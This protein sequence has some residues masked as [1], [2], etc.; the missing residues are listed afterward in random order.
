MK[1]ATLG[2]LAL[3]IGG[4]LLAA[5]SVLPELQHF[6]HESGRAGDHSPP[7]GRSHVAVFR[8]N[9]DMLADPDESS[10]AYFTVWYGVQAVGLAELM[11]AGLVIALGTLSSRSR[12][13]AL[14]CGSVHAAAFG[15]LAA[16]AGY[17]AWQM[18]QA[19]ASTAGLVSF[20]SVALL[21][22]LF[23]GQ[24]WLTARAV[25]RAGSSRLAAADR[26][27][28]LPA[29]FFFVV[30]GALWFALRNHPH[31]PGGGYLVSAIGGFLLLTGMRLRRA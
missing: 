26:A 12:L 19:K 6:V 21:T 23:L 28:L 20:L 1:R 31:W 2:R 8:E 29:L 7:P 14:F 5:G 24:A 13:L 9:A 22:A 16:G 15:A 30:N 27:N 3:L 18:P 25:R 10:P 17:V 4:L 11:V